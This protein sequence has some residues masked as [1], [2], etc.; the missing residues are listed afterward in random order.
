MLQAKNFQY[1]YVIFWNPPDIVTQ[2]QRKE[3]NELKSKVTS[4]V[5]STGKDKLLLDN[6]IIQLNELRNSLVKQYKLNFIPGINEL[7]KSIN[8]SKER[9]EMLKPY[10]LKLESEKLIRLLG[11]KGI[12]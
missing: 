1:N 6:Y 3:W 12:K 11:N 4:K 10:H 2:Q 9:I 5:G 8:V 7:N